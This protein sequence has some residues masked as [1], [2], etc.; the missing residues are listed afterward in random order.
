MTS[1]RQFCYVTNVE[2]TSR[3][4]TR[5]HV[6]RSKWRHSTLRGG[7]DCNSRDLFEDCSL[8]RPFTV[9]LYYFKLQL[10]YLIETGNQD[11]NFLKETY[12]FG[13]LKAGTYSTTACFCRHSLL[14]FLSWFLKARLNKHP[15]C[16]IYFQERSMGSI[17]SIVIFKFFLNIN[18]LK[19][20]FRI[21]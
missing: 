16:Q 13:R 21:L 9:P 20:I 17:S 2:K 8:Q 3:W 18:L 14:F 5:R 12:L 11:W 4:C 10:C 6:T 15:I 7:W 19:D 1:F